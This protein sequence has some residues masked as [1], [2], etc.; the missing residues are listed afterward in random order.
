MESMIL[1]AIVP[2]WVEWRLSFAAASEI[3]LPGYPGWSL[4]TP[5]GLAR[6][7]KASLPAGEIFAKMPLPDGSMLIGTSFVALRPPTETSVD[8]VG[9][10]ANAVLAR[11]RY[12]ACQATLARSAIAI[13]PTSASSNEVDPRD[14][15]VP[16][17][18]EGNARRYLITTAISERHLEELATMSPDFTVPVHVEVLLDGIDAH[19]CGDHRR[20]LLYA[21]IAVEAHA[22]ER[23]EG[24]YREALAERDG[25]HRVIT[26]PGSGGE[27]V[28]DPVYELISAN[29]HFLRLLHERPLYLLKRSLMVDEPELYRKALQLRATRNKI[30]HEGAPPADQR[31]FALDHAG[32][33]EGLATALAVLRWFGD[34]RGYDAS[35][36]FVR[37]PEDIPAL[38]NHEDVDIQSPTF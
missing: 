38:D 32:S 1:I 15:L 34:C 2:G 8:G 29:D 26:L 5:I 4:V 3:P 37:I 31:Y 36:A 7:G 33:A 24:A 30:A 19:I 9:E 18:L 21:A 20:A 22:A 28:K 17:G 23:L 25:A 12:V 16:V 11:L 14:A 27:V 6:M 10:V 13:V 35:D